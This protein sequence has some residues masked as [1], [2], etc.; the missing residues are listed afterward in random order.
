M[1]EEY[2]YIHHVAVVDNVL[3]EGKRVVVWTTGCPFHCKGCIEEKLQDLEYGTKYLIQDFY[4]SIKPFL[5]KLKAVTFSGGEPLFQRESFL[6]LLKL[7]PLDVD[8][9]LYT[10]NSTEVFNHNYKE[11]H[12]YIDIVV[13]EPFVLNLHSNHL[14]RGSSNQRMLSPSGKHDVMVPAWMEESSKG[15]Q[16]NI[17]I[18]QLFIYGIP[19]P[20]AL[21]TV[22]NIVSTQEI[23][24]S[25]IDDNGKRGDE[26]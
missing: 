17:N 23:E 3:G 18:E 11:F 16:V 1:M 4:K 22:R 20:N 10:G 6:S 19:V 9:M 21:D 12:E 25:E 13:T 14:W 26:L 7:I 2:I 15:I 5:M 8:I 24:I